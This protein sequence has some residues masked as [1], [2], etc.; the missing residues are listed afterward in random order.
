MV[1]LD[2]FGC[3]YCGLPV[4]F[5]GERR[6]PGHVVI[7]HLS[8]GTDADG[9]PDLQVLHR[10][11]AHVMRG[12][13]ATGVV[14]RRAWLG[15][16]TGEYEAWQHEKRYGTRHYLRLG[17]HTGGTLFLKHWRV[18]KMRCAAYA[19]RYYTATRRPG[20]PWRAGS[21]SRKGYLG[22]T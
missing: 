22:V 7:E 13:A 18:R 1:R 8:P 9:L 19:C 21:K 10:F 15:W 16:A 12:G 2:G 5:S 14:L 17:V 11:C 6:H 3:S 4:R 20:A